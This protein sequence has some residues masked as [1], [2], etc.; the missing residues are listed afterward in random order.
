MNQRLFYSSLVLALLLASCGQTAPVAIEPGLPSIGN[1]SNTMRVRGFGKGN[2]YPRRA[3]WGEQVEI[4]LSGFGLKNSD[5]VNVVIGSQKSTAQKVTVNSDQKVRFQ[6]PNNLWGGPQN[7]EVLSNDMHITELVLNVLGQSVF[8]PA[9]YNQP[10][11]LAIFKDRPSEQQFKDDG[12][13]SLDS[14]VPLNETGSESSVLDGPCNGI[15][16]EILDKQTYPDTSQKGTLKRLSANSTSTDNLHSSTVGHGIQRLAASRLSRKIVSVGHT[17]AIDAR[18]GGGTRPAVTQSTDFAKINARDAVG[19]Q[20]D[21]NGSNT[22]IAVLD[23]GVQAGIISLIP[24]NNGVGSTSYLLKSP[25]PFKDIQ[26]PNGHGTPVSV[27]AAEK[28]YGIAS[29]ASVLSIQACEED[30]SCS[31]TNIVRGICHAV[32][33]AKTHLSEQVVL[34]LSLGSETPS[35]IV[36][37]ILQDALSTQKPDGKPLL[38]VAAAAGNEWGKKDQ[39]YGELFHYP[40]AFAGIEGLPSNQEYAAGRLP[41]IAGLVAVG[42]V[43][44]RDGANFE[45]SDFSN[46]GDYITLVAPGQQVLSLDR[47]GKPRTYDG[48]SFATP[49]VSGTLAFLSKNYF[50]DAAAIKDQLKQLVRPLPLSSKPTEVGAGMLDLSK[51]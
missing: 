27:L 22:T 32:N 28:T 48:T 11:L 41:T 8:Y 7:L 9:V 14:G 26:K 44:S 29:G 21:L 2:I 6:V 5:V 51:L 16:Y 35:E 49:I 24:L 1:S 18:G 38:L 39:N 20:K 12:F 23:S 43:G 40:A 37:V 47:S 33:Y 45:V 10:T 31:L 30:G 42:A 34:N 46:R 50:G 19:L 17:S 13:K 4:D 15:L 3:A 25:N 36:Y